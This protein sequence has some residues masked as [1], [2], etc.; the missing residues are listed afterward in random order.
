M[1]AIFKRELKSF[2]YSPIGYIF[3]G[4]FIVLC[5]FF[6]INGALMYQSANLNIIFSNINVVYL[7]LVSILTMGLFSSERSRKTDQ[8][9]LT[10]PVSVYEIVAGKFLAA[11]GV[12]GVTL[13]LS[14]VYPIIL[15]MFGNPSISEMIGSYIGFILLWSAFI[16]IGT[17][18]S[19]T[20]ESQTIAAVITFGVL[21]LVYYMNSLVTGFSNETIK[22]VVLWFSLMDRYKDFQTGILDIEGVIYYLSFVFS[23]CFLTAQLIRR[24]QYSDT[25]L[26][27][28]NLIVTI[29]TIAA[30]ILVNCIVSTI[31]SKA[32]LKIDLTHDNVYKYSE[33]TKEVLD[34]LEGDVNIYALYP[35]DTDGT[36]VNTLREYL[37]RYEKMNSKI[38][39]S[40]KDPYED[41]AFVRQYGSDITVGSVIVEQGDRF[42]VIAFESLFSQS[43]LDGST[44]IDAEKQITSAI[45]YVSGMSEGVNAYFIKGHNEHA[46]AD[47][48][49]ASAFENEGYVVGEITIATDGIPEDADLLISLAPAADF[50]AEE[51]D[52]LDTYLLGGGKAAFA[53][54]SGTEPMERLYAYLGEWGII[55]NNDFVV[56]SDGSMA[57]KTQ[58][59]VPVPAPAMQDHT[60][61]EKLLTGDIALITPAACSFTINDNNPQ[62]A[63]ITPL[64]KTSEASWGVTDL[65]GS[66][67]KKEGDLT[68]PLTIAALAEKTDSSGKIFVIGSVQ[69]IEWQGILDNSSY[70]NGDFI[71]NAFSYMTDKGDALNIRAKEISTQSLTMSEQQFNTSVIFVQYIMPL[72]VLAIGLLVW[73]KRR[74]L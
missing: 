19:A 2:F 58:T 12:F 51:R 61:T 35:D 54:T 46:G 21:L 48:A 45:R 29:A 17:F 68:G 57:F 5:S 49:L 3:A 22:S 8:L 25:K 39:V 71:L 11:L 24:R 4:V 33:Q 40:Y 74:Y 13:L 36:Y 26:R 72:L 62:Y 23:F 64:L 52:A 63:K 66:M 18:I 15:S 65:S 27:T 16:A 69:A 30:V 53:F 6:F 14:L 44:S 10:S 20:T 55:A 59:G 32:P 43:S 50:S 73:L 1:K 70:S 37:E 34:N 42:R 9:L 41:P 56:E 28:G 67:D 31:G 47:S 7:F 38:T 60:I